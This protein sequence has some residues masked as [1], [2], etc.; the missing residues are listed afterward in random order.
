MRELMRNRIALAL[1][2]TA[3]VLPVLYGLLALLP[4]PTAI[5]PNLDQSWQYAISRAAAPGKENFGYLVY[6]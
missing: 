6:G 4:V 2:A 5:K 1:R 3:C